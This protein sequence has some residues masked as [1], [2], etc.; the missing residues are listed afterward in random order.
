MTQQQP[1]Q[2]AVPP[3]SVKSS[4][5]LFQAGVFVIIVAATLILFNSWQIWNAHQRDLRS[6]E[7]E[8]ANLARSLAQHADDTFMQVDGNLLDLTERLQN[9][10]LG[11]S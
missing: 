8:S 6:A 4:P 1:I 3:R 10:G 5:L 2:D 9:D 11:P 7:H